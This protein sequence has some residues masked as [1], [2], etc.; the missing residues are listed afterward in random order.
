[1]IIAAAS[2][3]LK[4]LKKLTTLDM[5]LSRTGFEIHETPLT[6][7]ILRNDRN[8]IDFLLSKKVDVNV[9]DDAYKSPLEVASQEPQR[10]EIVKLLIEQGAKRPE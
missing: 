8:A 9:V 5:Y 1:M 10:K 4:N 6:T 3:N 7:A 2:G